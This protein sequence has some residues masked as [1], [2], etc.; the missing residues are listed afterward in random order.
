MVMVKM[1]HSNLLKLTH[2]DAQ[3]HI[4]THT[5]TNIHT[6]THTDSHTH[7][8]THTHITNRQYQYVC[9]ISLCQ[10]A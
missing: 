7:T 3:T 10:E 4:H 8:H 1:R 6:D 5:H 2:T 9:H